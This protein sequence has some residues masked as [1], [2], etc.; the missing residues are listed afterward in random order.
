MVCVYILKKVI[1]N[2]FKVPGRFPA[3]V[4][5]HVVCC[6][7]YYFYLRVMIC[8]Y[9]TLGYILK[10]NLSVFNTGFFFLSTFL[11]VL[12]VTSQKARERKKDVLQGEQTCRCKMKSATVE[13]FAGWEEK[14]NYDISVL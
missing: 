7:Y 11:M 1:L 6:Y 14:N 8:L 3:G 13:D 2:L 4:P 10:G 5:I 12:G 9:Y